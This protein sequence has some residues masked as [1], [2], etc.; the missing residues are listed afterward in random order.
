MLFY[1]S[2]AKPRTN[3]ILGC[4]SLS[5]ITNSFKTFQ[6]DYISKKFKHI[7]LIATSTYLYFPQYTVPDPP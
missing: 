2:K 1:S 5:N 3:I 4:L 7:F 6:S